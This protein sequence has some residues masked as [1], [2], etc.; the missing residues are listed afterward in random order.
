[1]MASIGT[2]FERAFD[3]R[4][5]IK[6]TRIR[7]V[8]AIGLLGALLPVGPLSGQSSCTA[9]AA[10]KNT[11][12]DRVVVYNFNI[13]KMDDVGDDGRKMW[14][15]WVDAVRDDEGAFMP[16]VLLLQDMEKASE[17]ENLRAYLE[18]QLCVTYN[19]RLS[20]L[21]GDHND[22]AIIFRH[23]LGKPSARDFNGYGGQDG[24]TCT[25]KHPGS[26]WLQ[27]RLWDKRA[28]HWIAL[29][30]GKTNPQASEFCPYRNMKLVNGKLNDSGWSGALM[31]VGTDANSRDYA[32]GNYRCW[33]EPTV[34]DRPDEN[35]PNVNAFKWAYSDPIYELCGDDRS[36]LDG[37]SCPDQTCVQSANWTSVS[38]DAVRQ[39][40]DFI[41]AKRPGS[42]APQTSEA[43][44]LPRGNSRGHYSDHR[45]IRASI[46]Y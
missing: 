26:M 39:R 34:E 27:M 8:L 45:A 16:D 1:M 18:S 24:A 30:S 3:G 28:D 32:D 17:A 11:A 14:R 9:P 19:M 29:A 6:G 44:T 40:I 43:E 33:Y 46:H 25:E 36:C 13:H 12:T 42:A 7:F 38:R 4:S 10:A 21:D 35:C 41:F 15:D 5:R 31:I 20:T 23:R 22:A 2:S 37:A